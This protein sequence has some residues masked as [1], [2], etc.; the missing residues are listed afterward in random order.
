MGTAHG[1]I[2]PSDTM[3]RHILRGTLHENAEC[4]SCPFVS[5]TAG[6]SA[7]CLPARPRTQ[8]QIAYLRPAAAASISPLSEVIIGK[9][10]VPGL[11]VEVIAVT[12]LDKIW[13][14]VKNN[15][16]YIPAYSALSMVDAFFVKDRNSRWSGLEGSKSSSSAYG[17][18]PKNHSDER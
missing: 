16:L 13:K 11:N 3:F 10:G 17:Q 1:K 5:S 7:W 2:N 12:L 4:P 15:E 14:A 18:Y 8:W 6:S 9:H